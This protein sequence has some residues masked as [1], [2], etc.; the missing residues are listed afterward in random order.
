LPEYFLTD[1]ERSKRSETLSADEPKD[2]VSESNPKEDSGKS[3]D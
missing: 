2:P 3:G 1:E